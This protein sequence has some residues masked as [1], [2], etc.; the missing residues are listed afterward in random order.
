LEVTDLDAMDLLLED[1][2]LEN[3]EPFFEA[4]EFDTL[5]DVTD[6]D[7][8][9]SPLDAATDGVSDFD[10]IEQFMDVT[11]SVSNTSNMFSVFVDSFVS[12]LSIMSPGK[13]Q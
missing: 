2:D 1:T 10:A 6:F 11:V 4:I 13:T 7:A 12:F 9:D 5:F 3:T 8:T